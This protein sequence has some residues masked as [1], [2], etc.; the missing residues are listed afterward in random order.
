[1]ISRQ[2]LLLTLLVGFLCICSG[3]EIRKMLDELLEGKAGWEFPVKMYL[4][5]LLENSLGDSAQLGTA[6]NI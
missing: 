4:M 2:I 3:A 1:M 5:S 6:R